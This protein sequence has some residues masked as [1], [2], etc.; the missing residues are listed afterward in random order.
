MSVVFCGVCPHPPIVVPEVGGAEAERVAATSAALLELGGRLKNSGAETVV[1]ISPHA[2]IFRDVV[3]INLSP[4]LKGDLS[5]FRARGVRFDLENDRKLAYEIKDQAAG[6]GITVV[7][8]TEDIIRRYYISLSLDHGVTVPLYFLEKAGVKLPLVHV[9]M[10]VGPPEK[11]YLFGIAVR[12]AAESLGRKVALLASG[13]L[14][15]CLTYGAPGGF[16]PRGEEFDEEMARLL[17]G[18]DV[19]GVLQ[20]DQNLVDE[21]GECGYRSIVMMLGA[22]DGYD[23]KGEV[24]SYEGPFGVGYLVAAYQ[25]TGKNPARS[26]FEKIWSKD[27]KNL[28]KRREEESYLVKIARQTL[29]SY[30]KGE[31]EPPADNIPEE[32]KSK[33]G[34]FVS[35]KK[36][37]NLRGCIG[38]IQPTAENV[39]EEVRAN[40]INA[41]IHDPRF[42]PVHEEELDDLEYS[43][44]VL[45]PPEPISGMEELDP[46]K[47]GV[48]VR[49]G[50]KSGLLL[51]NLEGIDTVEDQVKIARQKAGIRPNEPVEL[52]RFEVV[53][54]K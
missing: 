34:V 54:Y 22:L 40:A 3:G 44:D 6:L 47:Y 51:P 35:I 33:A 17:A 8:L 11:L 52:E 23:V 38:T 14:S 46:E 45:L 50:R 48:I 43:V 10:T 24:L 31:P 53:R 39:V 41:G 16:N 4:V 12:G 29:E 19:E 9:S 15:H 36:R 28:L 25:P 7:E 30:V 13:D 37:G 26:L 27:R 1:I 18:P 32:F 21:A 20:L 42:M 5:N 2:P 49:S